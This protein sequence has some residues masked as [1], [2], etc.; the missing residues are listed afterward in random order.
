[1][2]NHCDRNVLLNQYSSQ[3]ECG[4]EYDIVGNELIPHRWKDASES[5][6]SKTDYP[7]YSPEELN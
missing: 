7:I 2:C 1:M 5:V 4:T 6:D 3:C